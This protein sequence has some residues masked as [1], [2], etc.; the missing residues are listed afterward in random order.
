LF[1]FSFLLFASTA[2]VSFLLVFE[3]AQIVLRAKSVFDYWFLIF[4]FGHFSPLKMQELTEKL[5]FFLHSFAQ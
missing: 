3:S 1:A 4:C 2:E 5:S